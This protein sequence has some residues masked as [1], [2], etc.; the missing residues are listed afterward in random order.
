M[1]EVW[2]TFRP[3]RGFFSLRFRNRRLK[4][5]LSLGGRNVSQTSHIPVFVWCFETIF[6]L[7]WTFLFQRKLQCE[8]CFR[9]WKFPKLEEP[10][11]QQKKAFWT[12]RLGACFL[13]RTWTS[14]QLYPESVTVN[15][16]LTRN[17]PSQWTNSQSTELKNRFMHF[18]RVLG[19]SL[20][21]QPGVVRAFALRAE[22]CRFAIAPSAFSLPDHS[23]QRWTHSP[24][25]KICS[26][27]NLHKKSFRFWKKSDSGH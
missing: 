15:M 7:F 23:I 9:W 26:S 12:P 6:F 1:W 18:I 20:A 16:K 10:G 8:N 19:Q 11:T 14:Y 17:E 4:K 3:L 13:Q 5:P 27:L 24:M 21:G 2:E 25:E 22:V